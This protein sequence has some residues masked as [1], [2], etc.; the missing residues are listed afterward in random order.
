VEQGIRGRLQES[1][2]VRAKI[3]EVAQKIKKRKQS[4]QERGYMEPAVFNEAS[5]KNLLRK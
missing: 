2:S 4:R 3:S 1:S 5:G